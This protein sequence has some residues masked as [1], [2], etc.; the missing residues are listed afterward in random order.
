MYSSRPPTVSVSAPPHTASTVSY[1]HLDVYKRQHARRAGEVMSYSNEGYAILS[2]IVDQ[3]AGVPLEQ[4]MQARIF[5]PLS[6]TRTIL[7]NGVEAARA[8]SGGNIDVYKRQGYERLR[9][10]SA[11]QAIKNNRLAVPL[12][13]AVA[14]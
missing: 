7:D 12:C 4:F 10:R 3:A 1:T 14:A 9:A 11:K 6:M 2:Y 8:L 13:L 5:D